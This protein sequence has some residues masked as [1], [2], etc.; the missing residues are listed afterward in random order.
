MADTPSGKALE[1]RQVEALE[2]IAHA[3]EALASFKLTQG[4]SRYVPYT[5]PKG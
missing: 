3:L 5:P 4:G 2:K 1:R